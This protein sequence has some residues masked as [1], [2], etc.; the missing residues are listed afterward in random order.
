MAQASVRAP[1]D[2]EAAMMLFLEDEILSAKSLPI[3]LVTSCKSKTNFKK[4]DKVSSKT[5]PK[6]SSQATA[7]LNDLSKLEEKLSRQFQERFLAL[8]GKFDRRFGLFYSTRETSE[9]ITAL[10]VLIYHVETVLTQLVCSP[11]SYWMV[12]S[13]LMD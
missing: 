5:A 13:V 4:P 8:D 9:W 1:L 6:P 3:T 11:L 10:W 7:K 12:V 2:E